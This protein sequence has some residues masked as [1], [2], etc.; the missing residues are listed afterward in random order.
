MI[1]LKKSFDDLK[2]IDVE[3][4]MSLGTSDLRKLDEEL[5]YFQNLNKKILDKMIPIIYNKIG[6][7]DLNYINTAKKHGIKAIISACHGRNF[8]NINPFYLKHFNLNKKLDSHDFLSLLEIKP[9][10]PNTVYPL[11]GS[12]N[13][14]IRHFQLDLKNPYD[15]ENFHV[16]FTI[17]GKKIKTK[18]SYED[19]KI[20]IEIP[21][22]IEIPS[23]MIQ[24]DL[25][26]NHK[27]K[28]LVFQYNWIFNNHSI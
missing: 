23:E 24:A 7:Y 17:N 3:F 8:K 22:G 6:K 18:I 12:I 28:R 19:N 13:S 16:Y 21:Q 14:N 20:Y 9:L 2:K 15:F 5:E 1:L 4:G 10:I 11:E 25:I 27:R 26:M